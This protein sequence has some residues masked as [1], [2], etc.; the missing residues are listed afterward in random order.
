MDTIATGLFI[1]MFVIFVF[2]FLFTIF[3]SA[4]T[5]RNN[6]KSPRI[7]APCTI[8][9]HRKET[10]INK[11]NDYSNSLYYLTLEFETGDRCEY[12]VTYDAFSYY[13]DGD[14][15]MVTVKGN[16]FITFELDRHG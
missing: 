14:K 1:S 9:E 12:Q 15:G 8:V 3:K 6:S 7:K 4:R 10:S 2:I 5:I 11:N 16:E 13:V